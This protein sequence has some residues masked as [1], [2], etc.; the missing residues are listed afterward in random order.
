MKNTL[1]ILFISITSLIGCKETTIETKEIENNNIMETIKGKTITWE[2]TKGAFKGG[3]Y[4]NTFHK[5]GRVHWRGI[6]GA[7]AGKDGIEK[8]Y[9]EMNVAENV[10]SISWL[11]S[12]GYTVTVT[13]NFNNNTIYGIASNEKEWYP[14]S[15][16][17]KGVE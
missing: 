14:L 9:S 16:V 12:I 17:I 6:A 4:K 1:I 3:I 11:E 13:L 15:G 10:F 2:W 7:E 8:E 5:D